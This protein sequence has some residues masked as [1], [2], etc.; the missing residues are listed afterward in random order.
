LQRITL[1]DPSGKS[2][3]LIVG[4][5]G[6]GKTIFLNFLVSQT[7][8]FAPRRIKFDKNRSTRIPTMFADGKF[9][10]ATGKFAA[11]TQVNPLSMLVDPRHY[12]YVS[13]WVQ[14]AIEGDGED[15]RCTPQQERTIYERVVTLAQGYGPEFW[16]LS[17]L[18]TLL[19]VEL[20]DR[21]QIWTKGE[22]NGR[23]FDHVE[24]AFSYPTTWRSRWASYS[25]AIRW[26]PRCSWTTRSTASRNG[27]TESASRSLRSRSAASSSGIRA[28]TRAWRCGPSRFAG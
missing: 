21:L 20:R 11:A 17:F 26:P 12:T 18:T 7:G 9:V 22:K 2:H 14:M 8:R 15:F 24:D 13:G 5:I 10:D 1:H 25:K 28:S 6:A 23:F 27:W 19:P 4:P 3:T 16:T